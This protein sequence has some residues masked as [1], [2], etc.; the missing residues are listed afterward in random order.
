MNSYRY[1]NEQDIFALAPFLISVVVAL[2]ALVTLTAMAASPST[3]RDQSGGGCSGSGT[4]AVTVGSFQ[5]APATFNLAAN[6]I[7][8][9]E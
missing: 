4:C 1:A 9:Q 8:M 3:F 6:Q 2:T 5:S 7:P